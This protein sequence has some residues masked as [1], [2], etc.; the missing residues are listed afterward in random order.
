MSTRFAKKKYAAKFEICVC[1]WIYAMCLVFFFL[2]LSLFLFV[3]YKSSKMFNDSA[4][5]IYENVIQ[6]SCVAYVYNTEISLQATNTKTTTTTKN[7]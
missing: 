4:L 5:H 7:Q 6:K 3:L 2:F 1:V